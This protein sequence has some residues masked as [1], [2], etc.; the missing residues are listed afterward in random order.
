ME[1][2]ANIVGWVE[3]PVQE[4]DRAI[5][6]YETVFGFVL[7]RHNLGVLDMA[8]FPSVHN[9]PGAQGSLVKSSHYKPSQD[10]ILIY[11]A[12][13]SG[14]LSLELSRVEAA[15]GKVLR[16]KTQISPEHGFMGLIVDSEGNRIA[17][18]SRQ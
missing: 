5:A 7:Q 16:A 4:M 17:L 8:W 14:D 13:P 15:G 6:F 11:F 3:V 2:K 9:G 10:G 12:A 1:Q 18:H